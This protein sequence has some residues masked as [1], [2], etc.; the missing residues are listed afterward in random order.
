[1]HQSNPEIEKAPMRS[2]KIAQYFRIKRPQNVPSFL[3]NVR[4]NHHL[5]IKC[6]NV[7]TRKWRYAGT[8]LLHLSPLHCCQLLVQ[9]YQDLYS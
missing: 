6:L 2:V 8:T 7:K 9:C 1:M 3:I 4:H 5:G